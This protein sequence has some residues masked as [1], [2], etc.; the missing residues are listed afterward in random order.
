MNSHCTSLIAALIL[1]PIV[2][3][4]QPATLNRIVPQ[5]AVF[6]LSVRDVKTATPFLLGKA[7]ILRRPAIRKALEAADA[8]PEQIAKQIEDWVGV[9]LEDLLGVLSGPAVLALSPGPDQDLDLDDAFGV[10]ALGVQ[11]GDRTQGIWKRVL[12]RIED[13][14][15][16]DL[17]RKR[18]EEFRGTTIHMFEVRGEVEGEE[19]DLHLLA[20]HENTVLFSN[21]RETIERAILALIDPEVPGFAGTPGFEGAMKQ[22]GPAQGIVVAFD[23][24]TVLRAGGGD[25]PEAAKILGALGLDRARKFYVGLGADPAALEARLWLDV[26]RGLSGLPAALFP[27]VEQ[28][29]AFERFADAG[30][31]DAFAW[32]LDPALIGKELT[33]FLEKAFPQGGMMLD[34]FQSELKI[35]LQ[36]DVL[37]NLLPP[38]QAT[39]ASGANLLAMPPRVFSLR[40]RGPRSLEQLLLRLDEEGM[41]ESKEYMG[42]KIHSL[43]VS[44][45]AGISQEGISFAVTDTHI[46]FSAAGSAPIERTLRSIGKETTPLTSTDAYK[47]ALSGLPSRAYFVQFSPLADDLIESLEAIR[48]ALEYDED[49]PRAFKTFLR[50]LDPADIKGSVEHLGMAGWSDDTGAGF[51]FRVTRPQPK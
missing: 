51:A 11:G 43:E 32:H 30:V 29:V 22:L 45:L 39:T 8:T 38:F 10:I 4:A 12:I 48:M 19:G 16:E 17:A 15:G 47:R 2:A 44:G 46:L 1:I 14:L 13:A 37:G 18:E 31:R 3:S 26:P 6:Y 35:D 7:D 28:T 21:H 50:D 42:W 25:D 36:K 20:L 49:I 5:N 23:L 33:A 27:R 24:Q 34:F 41:V 40:C 9:P